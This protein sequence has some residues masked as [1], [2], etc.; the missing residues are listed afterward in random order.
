M[1]SHTDNYKGYIMEEVYKYMRNRY[2]DYLKGP[3]VKKKSLKKAERFSLVCTEIDF[4]KLLAR[5]V[6]HYYDRSATF[7]AYELMGGTPIEEFTVKWI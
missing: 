4:P 3:I 6:I 7:R 2:K 5:P 1:L